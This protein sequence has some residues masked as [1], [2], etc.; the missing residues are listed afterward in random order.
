MGGGLVPVLLA[1]RCVRGLSDSHG[2]SYPTQDRHKAPSSTPPR[3][4]SLQD[5]GHSHHEPT[6]STCNIFSQISCLLSLS[7]EF[8]AGSRLKITFTSEPSGSDS[9]CEPPRI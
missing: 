8:Q 6:N 1:P 7:R 3:P 4:L 2:S 9:S 5:A